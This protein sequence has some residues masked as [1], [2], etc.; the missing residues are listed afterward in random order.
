MREY[1]G[2]IE[3]AQVDALVMGEITLTG[4]TVAEILRI[5]YFV[6]STSIPHNFGWSAPPA[7]LPHRTPQV[8]LQTRIFEVSIFCMKGPVRRILDRYRHE[9]GLAPIADIGSTFPESAHITQWPKCL[10]VPR[11]ELPDR[12]F[13]TGPFVDAGARSSVAFPWHKLT[14]QPLVYASLGTTRKADPEIYHRI[15]LACAG[16]DLQLVITLGGRRNLE[17]FAN[18]PGN[19]LVVENA[20]QLDLIQRADLVITHAGPNTVLETLLSGKPMLALP[21]ALDQPAV[22]TH[23]ERLGVAQVI[24]PQRTSAHE[25][26]EALLKLMSQN[27]Y[28]EAAKA[29]QAEVQSLHGAAQAASIME[30][31]LASG[32]DSFLAGAKHNASNSRY[33]EATSRSN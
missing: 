12:F 17:S 11:K 15:A 3:A 2:A 8:E 28:R 27:R 25:I 30:E 14:G 26:R 1:R 32:R 33:S 22:A 13:Y 16:L 21:V 10:D 4:P 6:V 29:I 19:P 24:S 18:L 9:A 20:P 31:A 7:L 5:P 23:L